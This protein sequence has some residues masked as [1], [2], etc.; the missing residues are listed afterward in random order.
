MNKFNDFDLDLN[1]VDTEVELAEN[2]L[3][4]ICRTITKTYI[5]AC[6]KTCGGNC[7][8]PVTRNCSPSDMTACDACRN[9]IKK[10]NVEPNC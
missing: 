8:W 10:D 2:T 3:G 6:N 1:K 4:I 7:I 5:T 9:M